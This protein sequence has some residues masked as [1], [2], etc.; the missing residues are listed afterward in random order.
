[1]TYNPPPKISYKF[2][3][4]PCDYK[5]CKQSEYNKHILTS[6]HKNTDNILTNTASNGE[7]VSS[8]INIFSCECGKEYKHRQSLFNHRKKCK[9]NEESDDDEDKKS[10]E[11]SDKDLI[12]MIVKQN[13]ELIKENNE[14]KSM[15]MEVIKNGTMQNSHNT[16][17]SHNKAFNL[18]FF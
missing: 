9:P 5:C 8:N 12:M 6:K 17:N 16:T 13:T 1:M 4:E 14:F 2:V 10:D 3:C 15:M 11:I 7:K 18:Q